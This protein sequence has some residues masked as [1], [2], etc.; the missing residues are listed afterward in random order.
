MTIEEGL[1]VYLTTGTVDLVAGELHPE[2]APEETPTPFVTYDEGGHRR[3]GTHQG[4]AG[5]S[6]ST[7]GLTVT[8][9][10]KGEAERIAA[11]Y[12]DLFDDFV[13]QWGTVEIQHCAATRGGTG[14]DQQ[15]GQ[16]SRTVWLETKYVEG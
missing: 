10:T 9:D 14:H 8:A 15:T 1:V 4:Y 2:P 7:L 12:L 11:Y 5:V 16:R 6:E 13:G 3:F